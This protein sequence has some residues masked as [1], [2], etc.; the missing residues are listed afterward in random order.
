MA[1]EMAQRTKFPEGFDVLKR[2]GDLVESF[3]NAVDHCSINRIPAIVREVITSGAWRKRRFRNKVYEHEKFLDFITTSPLAGCG[4]EPAKVEAL[5]GNDAEVLTMW[6]EATTG[7][8][9]RPAKADNS[10]NVTIKPERGNS[11]AYT[12]DRLKRERPDLFDK[13]KLG[14]L[15]ANAAAIEA[16]FR[17]QAT[18]LERILSLLPKLTPTERR[19][20]RAR[21]DEILKLQGR[22]A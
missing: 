2:N 10:D 21:L 8:R 20:L 22:A 11:R 12:L 15:S 5:L 17:R 19:Q 18:P 14:K 6:R 9:G 16:G 1:D 4:W 7:K 3:W 13:V